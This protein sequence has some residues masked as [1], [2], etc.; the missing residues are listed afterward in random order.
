MCSQGQ[1]DE[2]VVSRY[3][4]PR[5]RNHWRL[6]WLLDLEAS[7]WLKDARVM[8]SAHH[9]SRCVPWTQGT[10]NARAYQHYQGKVL[11]IEG[12]GAVRRQRFTR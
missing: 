12:S 10:R 2:P 11:N 4:G 8:T 9:K 5:L 1:G 7:R 3:Q 6:I